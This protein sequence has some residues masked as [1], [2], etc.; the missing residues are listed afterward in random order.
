MCLIF[1]HQ[2]GSGWRERTRLRVRAKERGVKTS[3]V[4][5]LRLRERRGDTHQAVGHSL[6]ACGGCLGAAVP[7]H[8]GPATEKVRVTQAGMEVGA[9]VDTG[10]GVA[11]VTGMEVVPLWMQGEVRTAAGRTG[12]GEVAGEASENTRRLD[13]CWASG[14]G[15]GQEG[16]QSGVPRRRNVVTGSFW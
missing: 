5:G 16:D 15:E 8:Q 10:P 1:K 14:R 6:P 13:A 11:V 12:Q 4:N 2:H 3:V 7:D 9:G